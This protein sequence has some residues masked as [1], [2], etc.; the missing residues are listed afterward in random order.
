MEV[1]GEE[2]PI[3]PWF[4]CL[5]CL[6]RQK[7]NRYWV[8]FVCVKVSRSTVT[9]H[10]MSRCVTKCHDVSRCTS[11]WTCLHMY[12]TKNQIGIKKIQRMRYAKIAKFDVGPTKILV[13]CRELGCF[14]GS[15]MYT[16]QGDGDH[17]MFE[18]FVGRRKFLETRTVC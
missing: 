2:A 5:V 7:N 17:K 6:C 3:R 10:E 4:I 16:C 18:P 9:C 15:E 12:G 13:S 8:L 1:S 14:Y 11:Q